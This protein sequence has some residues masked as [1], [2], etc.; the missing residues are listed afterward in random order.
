MNQN[1]SWAHVFHA[2]RLV[3]N[4]G[5]V[6]SFREKRIMSPKTV[7]VAPLRPGVDVG[8]DRIRRINVKY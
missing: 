6:P 8:C 3:V 4:R 1:N 7:R 2:T 5:Q